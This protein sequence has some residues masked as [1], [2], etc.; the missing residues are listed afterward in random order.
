MLILATTFYLFESHIEYCNEKSRDLTE[1]EKQ[2][3]LHDWYAHKDDWIQ[4]FNLFPSLANRRLKHNETNPVLLDIYH[5][6]FPRKSQRLTEKKCKRN[7]KS[8]DIKDRATCPWYLNFSIDT[9]RYP[10]RL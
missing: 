2:R 3:Q 10:V 8:R 5:E 9:L 7:S 4:N 6:L 1:E